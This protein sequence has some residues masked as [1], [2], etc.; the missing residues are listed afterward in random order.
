M[1][2]QSSISNAR[3]QTNSI[4]NDIEDVRKNKRKARTQQGTRRD[5][6]KR[7]V[8]PGLM[9]PPP[10]NQIKHTFSKKLLKNI[11]GA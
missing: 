8:D 2:L 11:M 4:L 3:R 5:A 10:K 9:Y 7:K 6:K 1:R